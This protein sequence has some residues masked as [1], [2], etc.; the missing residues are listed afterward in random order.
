M[1]VKKKSFISFKQE[2]PSCIIEFLTWSV[3]FIFFLRVF[4]M[5]L[6]NVLINQSAT[7]Y[8]QYNEHYI[9]LPYIVWKSELY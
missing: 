3:E 4:V 8:L 5:E 7:I 6:G 9:F 1:F 2:R